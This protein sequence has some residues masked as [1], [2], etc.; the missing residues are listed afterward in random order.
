MSTQWKSITKTFLASI[1]NTNF[2]KTNGQ[3]MSMSMSMY[4]LPSHTSYK[5]QICGTRTSRSLSSDVGV[6]LLVTVAHTLSVSVF[7]SDRSACVAISVSVTSLP[8]SV[9]RLVSVSTIV[10]TVSLQEV[11]TDIFSLKLKLRSTMKKTLS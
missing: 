11:N 10:G 3:S 8:V 6:L 7:S 4:M 5:Y 2:L 9:V 1:N